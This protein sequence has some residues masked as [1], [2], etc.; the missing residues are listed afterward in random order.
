M[1]HGHPDFTPGQKHEAKPLDPE[2]DIDAKQA[3]ADEVARQTASEVVKSA[4]G[5][6]PPVATDMFDYTFESITPELGTQRATM[7]THSLGQ[8]PQQAGL[9][10]H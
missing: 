2:H 9:V 6:T 3:A 4:E 8:R 1:A 7:R 10:A 5:I